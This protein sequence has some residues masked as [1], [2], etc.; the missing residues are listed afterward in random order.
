VTGRR[1]F[2]F[3]SWSTF[4]QTALL[5]FA[6]LLIAQIFA[7]FLVRNIVDQ[8]RSYVVVDPAVNRFAEVALQIEASAP[9]K[10]SRLVAEANV[11][12]QSFSLS[13]AVPYFHLPAQTS[14]EDS[15]EEA[16]KDHGVRYLSVSAF[17]RG[18]FPGGRPHDMYFQRFGPA[19]GP[20][21][22]HGIPVGPAA[23]EGRVSVH[24]FDGQSP[25]PIGKFQVLMTRPDGFGGPPPD[26]MNEEVNLA[27]QLP[28]G[29]WLSGRFLRFRPMPVY[30]S[31]IFI[32]QVA[33][34]VAVL[35]ISL[36]WASRISRPVRMLARAAED[37]RPQGEIH[38]LPVKGPRDVRAAIVSFNTMAQRVKDLLLEKDR[39]LSAIGHDLRTP[40][41]SLRIRA[42]AVEPEAE[43]EKVVETID[44]MTKMVE[45]I[46][47]LARL[48]HTS[49]PMQ[50]VD[51][52]ALAD[53]L[54][55]EYRELGKD[56]AFEEAARVPLMIQQ[57][58]VRRLLRNLID[59]AVKYGERAR[60]SIARSGNAVELRVDDDG[61]GIPPSALSDVLRPFTR[62]EHSRSRETGGIGLGLSIANAIAQSQGA[63]L[64]LENRPSGGL[65]ARVTW[66]GPLDPLGQAADDSAPY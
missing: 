14:L 57:A 43:R 3:G 31:P 10:R 15:L 12:G 49:E 34:F 42:E 21:E 35:G 26:H 37:L 50:L 40:L 56:V 45:E 25:P 22:P 63:V 13:S 30:F 65:R 19:V 33:L 20:P 11:A 54:V 17:L 64:V 51:L 59:N 32:S 18:G 44:E 28:G 58:Q 7:F 60:V 48:G 46:L 2:D 38:P 62:L 16:L 5:I 39:M 8:W 24:D 27:A 6:A 29:M 53:S 55:E 9:E 41:A 23:I 52:A 4:G 61:P 36:F 1:R 47:S 66:K